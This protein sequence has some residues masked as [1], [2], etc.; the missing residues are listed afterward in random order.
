MKFVMMFR[1]IYR[2]SKTIRD[3]YRIYSLIIILNG[4][5]VVNVRCEFFKM[6]NM[7]HLTMFLFNNSHGCFTLL[8]M[9]I[10]LSTKFS[11]ALMNAKDFFK[12]T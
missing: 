1:D 2:V 11:I 9:H 12:C 3:N 6:S 4:K 10:V 8:S 5:I 7:S